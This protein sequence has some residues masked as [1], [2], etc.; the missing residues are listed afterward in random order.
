MAA[1]LL[2]NKHFFMRQRHADRSPEDV[3]DKISSKI[4]Y[5]KTD[6]IKHI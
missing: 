1:R 6:E 5:R 2:K 3:I 4:E